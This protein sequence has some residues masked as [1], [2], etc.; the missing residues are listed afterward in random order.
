MIGLSPLHGVP[1]A[2]P[3]AVVAAPA[4]VRGRRVAIAQACGALLG[5]VEGADE[6]ARDDGENDAGDQLEDEGVEPDGGAVEQLLAGLGQVAPVDVVDDVVGADLLADR[7]RD[8]VGDTQEYRNHWKRKESSRLN[9]AFI[10]TSEVYLS[11]E[12]TPML[13][14]L[15]LFSWKTCSLIS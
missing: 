12:R 5:L 3:V 8:V 10:F 4:V 6:A 11:T 15:Y 14:A 9:A 1:V 13:K 2:L 7:D